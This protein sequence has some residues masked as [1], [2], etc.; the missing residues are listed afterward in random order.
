LPLARNYSRC[1]I[2][3]GIT[4]SRTRE[5][6]GICWGF[7]FHVLDEFGLFRNIC[8]ALQVVT[9]LLPVLAR[10]APK[11]KRPRSLL[12]N[13]FS[14]KGVKFLAFVN[15]ILQRDSVFQQDGPSIAK[16]P[17][18]PR[19]YNYDPKLNRRS[20]NHRNPHSTRDKAS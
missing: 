19:F 18:L 14:A 5:I 3:C 8:T 12:D 10:D 15:R 9:C 20:C 6:T 13:L 16:A 4:L 11:G 1:S 2:C 17:P 7:G